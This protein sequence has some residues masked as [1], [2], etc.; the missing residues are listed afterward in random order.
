M[1]NAVAEVQKQAL[2]NKFR[3]DDYF[4]DFDQLNHKYINKNRFERAL[5]IAKVQLTRKQL[6]DL[7]EMFDAGDGNVD[8]ATF[9]DQVNE[10]YSVK[11]L[12]LSPTKQV[13]LALAG[14]NPRPYGL[15][16]TD[17]EA[18]QL[19]GIM[20][21][22]RKSQRDR[23]VILKNFFRDF[24]KNNTGFVS[25]SRF[26]RALQTALPKDV[27]IE[28]SKILAK[29]YSDGESICYKAFCRDASSTEAERDAVAAAK[30][31]QRDASAKLLQSNNGASG[32]L[33]AS[34]RQNDGD[35]VLQRLIRIVSE[36]K[37]RL[38]MFFD[39]FDKMRKGVIKRPKFKVCMYMCLPS[40]FTEAEMDSLADKYAIEGPDDFVDYRS[41]C[42]FIDLAFTAKNLEKSPQKGLDSQPWRIA[43]AP[44]VQLPQLSKD[45]E[46]TLAIG[47]RNLKQLV[48]QSRCRCR[49]CSVISTELA[50][51]QSQ[52][53]SSS[54]YC[55]CVISAP[56]LTT[57]W[58]ASLKSMVSKV[59]EDTVPC[60]FGTDPS[61][62]RLAQL[63]AFASGTTKPKGSRMPPPARQLLLATLGE[64]R[65]LMRRR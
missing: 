43:H 52:G 39:D 42:A 35:A 31:A 6:D 46:E 56:R 21:N 18:S 34:W 37:I 61:W 15:V 1:A 23:G 3:L 10:V 4:R 44:R 29:V 32:I 41:M 49:M 36:R 28:E 51:G 27:P 5:S 8:Y 24:D 59:A 50:G 11:G 64:R 48:N 25:E 26:H 17:D 54:V 38:R 63:V 16:L 7:E 53:T 58:S 65:E 12:E 13:R 9:C 20:L 14:T 55:L 62:R 30:T 22:V 19:P 45:D 47:M 40:E 60:L 33:S 2:R 57:Y